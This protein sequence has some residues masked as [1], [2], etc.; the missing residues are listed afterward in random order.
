LADALATYAKT[1]GGHVVWVLGPSVDAATYNQLLVPRGLLPAS[2]GQPV[3]ALKALPIDW[4]DVRSGLFMNLF[5]SRQPFRSALVTGRWTLNDATNGADE[6]TLAKLGDDSPIIVRHMAAATARPGGGGQIYTWLTSPGAE[7]SNLGGTVL[8]VP[9][10]TRMALGDY[11]ETGIEASYETGQSI[12]LHVTSP[13]ATDVAALRRLT[14]DVTT[15]NGAVIN[16]RVAEGGATQWTF[17]RAG[18]PGVY[19]WKTSDSRFSGAFAVNPPAEEADLSP[20]DVEAL[21]KEATAAETGGQGA[22]VARNLPDLLRQ[23]AHR[24]EGT[25]LMPGF[26][27]LVLILAVGEALLANRHRGG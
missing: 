17:N 6:H 5:D 14:V 1:G 15:P 23:L 8:L 19:S 12:P 21:A 9:L 25:T 16:V 2:L 7:W 22:M 11:Q 13:G 24:G 3:V 20:A 26:L 10:A 4:V 27:A 18:S